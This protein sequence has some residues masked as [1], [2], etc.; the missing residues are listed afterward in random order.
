MLEVLKK[1]K[2]GDFVDD[3]SILKSLEESKARIADLQVS[4]VCCYCNWE[5]IVE[6]LFF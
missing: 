2:N 1:E 3:I 6:D 4:F 5:G